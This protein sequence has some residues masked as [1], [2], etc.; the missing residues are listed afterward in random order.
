M[1]RH[2]SAPQGVLMARSIL[3]FTSAKFQSLR[4]QID[5]SAYSTRL[6]TT[7]SSKGLPDLLVK[8]STL[9]T[10]LGPDTLK[11]CNSFSL[12]GFMLTPQRNCRRTTFVGFDNSLN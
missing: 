9:I 6:I 10:S 12:A 8:L 1:P 4:C 2:I 3:N 7:F 5:P 11:A